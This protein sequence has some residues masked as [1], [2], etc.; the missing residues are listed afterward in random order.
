MVH[1]DDM[2]SKEKNGFVV[3]YGL[4]PSNN[5]ANVIG[6]GSGPSIKAPELEKDRN[7]IEQNYVSM[8]NKE[9]GFYT[10]LEESILTSGILNPILISAGF[11]NE[12]YHSWLPESMKTNP[13]TILACDRS[14]GSRLW[15]AQ[16]NNLDVMC[17]I[18]DFVDMF[19]G[20]EFEILDS[21]PSI[22]FKFKTNA[23]AKVTPEGVHVYGL[24]QVHL[25]ESPF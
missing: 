22:V 9:N 16:K 8:K 1:P 23:K 15:V 24:P 17:I 2:L 6:P 7:N 20:K 4:I 19:E 5:I 25:G 10:K 12:R 21:I 14:G 18:S 13:N 11:C 3:R